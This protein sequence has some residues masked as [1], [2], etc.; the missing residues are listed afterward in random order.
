[1]RFPN[2]AGT[3]ADTDAV[4]SAKLSAAGIQVLCHEF[5]RKRQK[6][7][8]T[9]IMGELH[10]WGFDRAWYYWIANG[11][12]IPVEEAEAL[13]AVHGRVVRVGGHCGCPNPREYYGGFGVGVYHVD[14]QDGL[15]ALA[16]TIRAVVARSRPIASDHRADTP[17]ESK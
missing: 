2:K 1:M 12:G 6:E 7:V 5:L 15:N 10:Q 17:G 11:P 13:H 3:H 16:A 4:L 14:T 9:A 8:K